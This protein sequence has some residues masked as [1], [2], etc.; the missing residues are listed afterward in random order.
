[1]YTLMIYKSALMTECLIKHITSIRA[2]TTMHTMMCYKIGLL[3]ECLLTHITFIR[4]LTTMYTLMCYKSELF[5]DFL[6]TQITS[7]RALSPMYVTCITALCTM[8]MHFFIQSSLVKT[9]RLN[10]RIY[11]YKN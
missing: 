1:M 9:Q 4:A 3:T 11:C 2:L 8:Y 6:I 10:I 7:V 5:I